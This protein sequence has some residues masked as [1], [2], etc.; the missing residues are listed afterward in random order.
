MYGS[1]LVPLDGSPFSEQALPVAGM[2]AQ[3]SGATLRLALVHVPFVIGYASGAPIVDSA[4]DAQSR[5]ADHAYLQA[6][7]QRL[8]GS[9]SLEVTATVLDGPVADALARHA[10][11]TKTDLVVMTTNGRGGL[12]RMWLGSVADALVREGPAPMLLLR[13]SETPPDQTQ[14]PGFQN[15]LIPL[16]GS[17]LA[18][19]ILKPAAELGN[20]MQAEYRLVQVV[21][22]VALRGYPPYAYAIGWDQE[23]TRRLQD[24]AAGYLEDT[25]GTVRAVGG[26][27]HTQVLSEHRLAGAILEYARREGM[28]L[29]A[30]STRGR[31]GIVR[32]LLGSVADK[33]LRGADMPVLIYRPADSAEQEE[34]AD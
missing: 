9:T 33:V 18:E 25:A 11:T 14:V 27:V 23:T 21:E 22:P 31:S 28:D 13:P 19:Q 34:P 12:A 15:I 2:L 20:L 24:A 8:A 32:L 17:Q 26:R 1:I 30:L 4:L 16:D 29:I 6:V 5:E 7:Q 3:R 10:A